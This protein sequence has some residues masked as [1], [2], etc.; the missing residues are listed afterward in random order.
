AGL[1]LAEPLPDQAR[2]LGYAP[3]LAEALGVA[4]ELEDW[5]GDAT[6]AERLYREAMLAAG[7]AGDDARLAAAAGARIFVLGALGEGERAIEAGTAATAQAIRSRTPALEG[8]VHNNLGA[9][10]FQL[11]RQELA[12]QELA[13][14]LKLREAALGPDHPLVASTLSNLGA[15]RR[16]QRKFDEAEAL[17]RRS[18]DIKRRVLG[19]EHPEVAQS[20]TNLAAVFEGRGDPAGAYELEHDALALLERA[21]GPTHVKVAESLNN[22]GSYAAGQGKWADAARVLERAVTVFRAA[23]P[24]AHPNLARALASLGEAYVH[25]GHGPDAVPVLEEAVRIHIAAKT[26]AVDLAHAQSA[27]AS[28]LVET[29]RDPARACELVTR[30]RDAYRTAEDPSWLRDSEALRVRACK[31]RR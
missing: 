4:A 17:H 14:A 3:V 25:L 23:L 18:L 31:G 21:M 15:V 6:K 22:L 12:G 16:V 24:P 9:T 10:Y 30:A 8:L 13:L 5:G 1:A 27:L 20:L 19:P 26:A 28:A 29:R 11:G 7:R 2:A